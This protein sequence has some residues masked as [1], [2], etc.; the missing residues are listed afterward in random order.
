MKEV[1]NKKS[2]IGGEF[3]LNDTDYNDVFI[4]EDFDEDQRMMVQACND[5][6]NKE[7]IPLTEK[8]EHPFP[9]F[10]PLVPSSKL[11]F[12][13]KFFELFILV[14]V[15]LFNDFCGACEALN[16]FFSSDCL[17]RNSFNVI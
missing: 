14:V 12:F 13:S 9:T 3:L 17:S 15:K 5:F 16:S 11:G 8:I 4:L 10:H 1:I 6:L 7:V 2:V